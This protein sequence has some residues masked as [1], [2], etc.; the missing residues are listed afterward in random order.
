M[1]EIK[2]LFELD[3][4]TIFVG[5]FVILVAIKYIIS[6]IGWFLDY[7][8]IEFKWKTAKQ[9]EEQL[10]KDVS[11]RID[12]IEVESKNVFSRDEELADQIKNISKSLNQIYGKIQTLDLKLDN[13]TIA[14]RESLA[15]RI[16][17]KYKYYLNINGIPEDEV[18]EFVE[19]HK[20]Y[21]GVG[22]N[23]SGDAKFEY[24]MNNL[25]IIPVTNKLNYDKK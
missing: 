23:H 5:L 14:S 9:K 19:L 13:T 10:L 1:T 2:N 11:E 21:K 6:L 24:C 22:G 18:D 3:M 12:L 4:P 17:N 16:N 25:K 7:F 20:A 8:G 15:D